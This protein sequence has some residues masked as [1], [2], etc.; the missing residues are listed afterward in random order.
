MYLQQNSNYIF[1]FFFSTSKYQIRDCHEFYEVRR[2][3]TQKAF[4]IYKLDLFQII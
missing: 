4:R 2:T 1:R 3:H